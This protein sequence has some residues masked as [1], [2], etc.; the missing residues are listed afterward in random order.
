MTAGPA[1]ELKPGFIRPYGLGSR[2]GLSRC[3]YRRVLLQTREPLATIRSNLGI[4]GRDALRGY[5]H[6]LDQQI[7][8]S[9]SAALKLCQLPLLPRI[10]CCNFSSAT[11]GSILWHKHRQ[12]F[13]SYLL[14]LWWMW[15]TAAHGVADGVFDIESVGLQLNISTVCAELGGLDRSWCYGADRNR[16]STSTFSHAKESVPTVTWA[17]ACAANADAAA[18]VF[19]LGSTFGYRYGAEA[20]CARSLAQTWRPE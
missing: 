10:L 1:Y 3:L 8:R 12:P 5:Y 17:E 19:R 9:D 4:I 14:H 20:D 11:V 6:M 2:K 13:I 16:G 15:M 7:A 18:R